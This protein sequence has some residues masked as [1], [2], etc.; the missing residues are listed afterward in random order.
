MPSL[1]KPNLLFLVSFANSR[2]IYQLFSTETHQRGASIYHLSYIL[3][4]ATS[5]ILYVLCFK[6]EALYVVL[7][8]MT[9]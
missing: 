4:C 6:I 1:L 9:T 8:G 3:L 2:Y 5:S 7:Q